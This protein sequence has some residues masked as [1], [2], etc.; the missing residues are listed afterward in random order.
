MGN[1]K[2]SATATHVKTAMSKQHAPPPDIL[3][4]FIMVRVGES[5]ESVFIGEPVIPAS[6]HTS[7]LSGR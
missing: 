3:F 7:T 5:K 2:V 1:V 4:L 6:I